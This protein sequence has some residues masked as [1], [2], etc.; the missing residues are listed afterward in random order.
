MLQVQEIPA[1]SSREI[2]AD[3]LKNEGN[4]LFK[5]GNFERAVEKYTQAIEMEP[6]SAV[7]HANRAM[8]HLKLEKLAIFSLVWLV[9]T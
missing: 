3:S 8:A 2:S 1:T 7:L 5:K 6:K 9:W 4:A